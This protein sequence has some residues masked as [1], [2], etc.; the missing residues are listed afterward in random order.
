M[1]S[2][3]LDQEVAVPHVFMLFPEL[4]LSV[5]IICRQCI[6]YVLRSRIS[7]VSLEKVCEV[8]FYKQLYQKYSLIVCPF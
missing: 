6:H 5:E 8:C 3:E 1:T 2:R 4:L 7:F